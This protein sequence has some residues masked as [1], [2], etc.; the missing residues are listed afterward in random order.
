[1]FRKLTT[2]FGTLGVLVG[3]FLLINILGSL[4]PEV[5]TQEPDIAPPAV[6]Y[7]VAQSQPITLDV[8]AR[9]EVNPR[10]EI[11]LTAQISGK[12]ASTSSAFVN[13]GAF[14]KGDLLIKIEDDDYRY[15]V[16]GARSNLAQAKELLARE[17]AEADLA[18]QDFEELGGDIQASDLTLRK[19]QLAQARANYDAAVANFKT[20][21]LNLDRT[22]IKAPFN[23]RVRERLAGPGQ[24][25]SPG[26]QIGRIFSTD[27][28]EIRLPLTDEDFAK[29]GMP[30]AF[31]ATE[32]NPGPDVELS[33]ILAGKQY[34]WRG[35]IKR[36]DGAI[37]AAT[38]QISAIAVVDDPY[39]AAATDGAPLAMGLFVDARIKGQPY[40][41]A[42][43]LPRIAL[44]GRDQVY[45]IGADNR[46]EIR[47][48]NVVSTSKDEI[49]IAGG[50]TNGDRV[51]TSPLRGAGDGDAVSPE[52]EAPAIARVNF[53]APA[54]AAPRSATSF[55]DPSDIA[56][57]TDTK[58]AGD[59]S[60]PRPTP[61]LTGPISPGDRSRDSGVAD[62]LN[63][64]Q[65]QN[66]FEDTDPAVV[67][68]QEGAKQ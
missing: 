63:R 14:K 10:T 2:V 7:T 30:I 8:F 43:V 4:R 38:R 27:V 35:Q 50:I 23:G 9:G 57:V 60:E 21:Q 24:F 16:T 11:S 37:D 26:A 41:D 68:A 51:V 32:D 34:F 66:G 42:F 53:L 46:L 62:H 33:G 44:H 12:V 36:T 18:Q 3:G 19:P 31:V 28:A 6:F 49:T 48:V 5:E 29:L 59:I 13:G 15:S 54:D 17:Q 55:S 1:M 20:A 67:A 52:G 45:V 40:N 64:L 22:E 58:S 65:L 39:G 25:V 47:T 61:R 56:I